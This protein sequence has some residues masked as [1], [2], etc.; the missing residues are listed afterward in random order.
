MRLARLPLSSILLLCFACGGGG[1]GGG[2]GGAP[3]PNPPTNF[4]ANLGATTIALAWDE[5]P[6]A[7]SYSIYYSPIAGVVRTPL[8]RIAQGIATSLQANSSRLASFDGFLAVTAMVGGVE[9]GLSNEVPVSVPVVADLDPLLSE[10]WHLNNTGQGGGVVG[11]DARLFAPYNLDRF[12]TGVRIA[13]IDDGLE[14]QHEDL[15]ANTIPGLC[16]DYVSGTPN[17]NAGD[18]GSSCAGVAAAVGGNGIGVIG[19][20]FEAH[21]VGYNLLVASTSANEVDAMTRGS[22]QISISSNSWGPTDGTGIPT[23]SAA[24]WQ[25]AIDLGTSTG[26]NGLGTIYTWAAG[27]GAADNGGF[28]TDNANLDGYANYRGVIAVGAIGDDGRKASYSESGANV[29]ISAHSMGNNDRGITTVDLQGTAGSNTGASPS[30]YADTNYT[31]TFNGTSSATP[32][33]TGVVALIL[34]EAPQLTER[35]VRRVLA[36]S[37]RRN[38]PTDPDWSVNGAGIFVNH[39]YGFGALDASEAF[40]LLPSYTLLGPQLPPFVSLIRTPNVAIPDESLSYVSDVISV[41]TA[42]TKLEHVEVLFSAANHPFLGDLR[43]E[44]ISPQA[45]VSVLSEPHEMPNGGASFSNWTFGVVRC[46]DENPNGNWQLRV[47]DEAG[48]DVGTFQSWRLTIRGR[49]Q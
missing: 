43:V 39:K 14:V 15:I 7:A 37:A 20:A 31:N 28:P 47:R 18:H 35:D 34:E 9:T 5:V 12:G 45:T 2:G 8:A 17:I 33:V 32:L 4:S 49:A 44:L 24:I 38:D 21:L 25:A 40:A 46:L 29:W 41:S 13:I 42:I 1:G 6:G 22:N 19:A 16:H 10:Q 23:P 48:G 26:R 11:E 36:L 3:P 30:D 27:N